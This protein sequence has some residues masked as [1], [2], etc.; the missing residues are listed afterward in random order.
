MSI[1][2]KKNTLYKFK[3]YSKY[4]DSGV[5]WLG[6]IPEG[7]PTLPIKRL[8]ST[9][10]TD[11]PHETPALFD[12]GVPFVSAESIKNQK[13]DFNL[14]RGYISQALHNIY[15]KKVKPKRDDIFF[16]K[17]GATTGAIAMVETDDE[18][19]IWSPLAVI[20]A[21]LS[22]ALPRYL[23][24]VILSREF[25]DQVMLSWSFGTQQN[26]GM[27]VIENLILS[28][29]SL[30]E[31]TAI[32]SFLDRETSRIDNIIEK[33]KTSIEKLHEYRTAL[34]SSAVTGKIDVRE[35]VMR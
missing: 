8:L 3:P 35:E 25:Q 32:A 6:E 14:K 16:V 33:V 1:A 10:I 2:P 17:S 24:F 26:I 28:T 13:V 31:Q 34:I 23:F 4:K 30:P 9:K 19:S 22:K 5:E 29:P 15:C 27:G 20:R 11:G 12:D 21:D 7:W 18:F